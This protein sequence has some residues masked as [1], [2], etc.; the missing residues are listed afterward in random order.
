MIH[1]RPFA[2][3][4]LLL[5]PFATAGVASAKGKAAP[6]PA[7]TPGLSQ[8]DCKPYYPY[9]SM[10]V[11]KDYSAANYYPL[12][13]LMPP[14]SDSPES[15]KPDQWVKAW[16]EVLLKHGWIIASP[17]APMFDNEES[18]SPLTASL[19]KV[20]ATYHID[21]RRIVI[22]GYA[23]GA[24]MAWRLGV[25]FPDLW[26]GVL[27]VSGEVNQLDRKDLKVL[28]GK[29]A[30]VF[31]G[32]K[33]P[34]YTDT[35]MKSDKSSIEYAK[36]KLTLEEKKD[37]KNDFPT[38]SLETMSKWLDDV[39]PGTYRDRSAAI[40]Q[41]VADKNAVA[42]YAALA[43]LRAELKKTP[44]PA[45]ELKAAALE[46][47]VTEVFRAPFEEAKKLL[48]SNPVAAI[49]QA[50]AA[51]KA[52]KGNPA[53]E[54]EAAAIVSALKKDPKVIE[55]LKARDAEASARAI[56]PKAEDAERKGDFAG[57]LALFRKIVALGETS[58]KT[59][60]EAK[61]AELEKKVAK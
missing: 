50:E 39:W 58:L 6:P 48:D 47:A 13:Y 35:M 49:E 56:L 7:A 17:A 14:V 25:K 10:A 26:A 52:L 61:V 27:A 34:G 59:D 60:C 12:L 3:A 32:L 45:F 1:P 44:Y 38:S 5:A 15:T 28:A 37:W 57:A 18:L 30:Y 22:G 41:A 43:E 19:K 42:G 11:P 29:P 2:L 53:L 21:E 54:K 4:L 8:L 36:I 40:E 46:K 24:I 9:I 33:D 20:L 23:A 16:S 51:L 55:A 31:R